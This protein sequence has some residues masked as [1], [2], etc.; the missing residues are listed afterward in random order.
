MCA[1]KLFLIVSAICLTITLHAQWISEKQTAN[2]Y[3]ITSPGSNTTIYVD[4]TD[5]TLVQKSAS[6][7]QE[8]I[9]RVTG[10]KPGLIHALPASA[11][12]II[13][14][15]SIEKSSL[16]QQ[17]IQQ[18]KINVDKI[19]NKWEAWQIQTVTNPFKGIEKCI[20]NYRQ[21]SQRYCL[22]GI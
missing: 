22:W 12:N 14:I 7:L 1:K 4:T 6:F 21:R 3:A 5:F 2:S 8:D 18:K 19:K 20:D 17:L 11:K 15:G 16:I 13:I 9:E 10:K